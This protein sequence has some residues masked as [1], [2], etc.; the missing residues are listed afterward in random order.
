M[1]GNRPL[2]TTHG[3]VHFGFRPSSAPSAHAIPPS[4]TFPPVTKDDWNLH[5][6]S[7]S[8]GEGWEQPRWR[9]WERYEG[10]TRMEKGG[11]TQSSGSI[12]WSLSV[13]LCH[14]RHFL[15]SSITRVVRS[16]R[17]S[18]HFHFVRRWRGGGK[19]KKWTTEAP[20]EARRSGETGG[21]RGSFLM[22]DSRYTHILR[23]KGARVARRLEVEDVERIG[24]DLEWRMGNGRLTE[25]REQKRYE[26]PRCSGWT[27]L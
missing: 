23:P 15:S 13:G 26:E 20:T 9:E 7:L 3:T 25:H 4:F 14:L 12:W 2:Q 18:L 27:G 16:L 11:P 5:E 6:R 21:L 19:W 10:D 24:E 17:R 1:G 22:S 8:W